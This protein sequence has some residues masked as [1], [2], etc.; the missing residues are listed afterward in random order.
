MEPHPLNLDDAKKLLLE[1]NRLANLARTGVNPIENLNNA[2]SLWRKA[3]SGFKKGTQDYAACLSNEANARSHLADL[4]NKGAKRNLQLSLLLYKQARKE[5]LRQ[6][7]EPFSINLMGEGNARLRLAR[8]GVNPEENL[9]KGIQLH[10]LSRK[11]GFLERSVNYGKS[12]MNE[13]VARMVLGELGIDPIKNL[14]DSVVLFRAS[15]NQGLSA[16]AFEYANALLNEGTSRKKL[17]EFGVDSITNLKQAI[18]LFKNARDIYS[19]NT[20]NRAETMINEGNARA[21]LSRFQKESRDELIRAIGLYTDARSIEGIKETVFYSRCLENEGTARVNLADFDVDP[22]DDLLKAIDLFEEARQGLTEGTTE[23]A[24]T[25]LNEASA[26]LKLA[27]TS[28]KREET[29]ESAELCFTKAHEFFLK[30]NN[31]IGLLKA[32]SGFGDLKFFKQD[33]SASFENLSKAI[34]IIETQRTSAKLPEYRKGYLETVIRVYKTMV[35]TCA[36]LEKFEEAFHFTESAK[37]RMFLELIGSEKK[38]F[39]A[40]PHLQKRYSDNLKLIEQIERAF[41]KGWASSSELLTL[42]SLKAIHEKILLSIKEYDPSYY[43]LQA[44]ETLPSSEVARILSGKTL[45]EYFVGDRTLIFVIGTDLKVTSVDVSESELLSK[46]IEL[47]GIINE[48]T[49]DN[50]EALNEILIFLY[51][52]LIRPVE[53][54]LSEQIVIVPHGILHLLPFQAL[55][56]NGKF[57]VDSYTA[58]FAISASLLGY[59]KAASS[60]GALVI[61]NP[62]GDLGFAELEAIQVAELLKVKP[63]IGQDATKENMLANIGEKQIIHFAGHGKFDQA[64]PMFSGIFLNDGILKALDFMNISLDTELFVLSGCSTAVS[65]ITSGDEIEG[66]LRAIHYSGSR[67]VIASLWNVCDESTFRLFKEFYG[68]SG[69]YARRLRSAENKLKDEGYSVYHWAPFQIYGN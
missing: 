54:L 6:G 67:Y 26:K 11:T 12:L 56:R 37:G 51:N 48:L 52:H 59:L 14:Q 44:V 68:K 50:A 29:L 25:Y 5:G 30:T 69:A 32:Y 58:T 17:A 4:D 2:M 9:N 20:V 21:I 45:I 1:G 36:H 15:R 7:S 55:K 60:G 13:G 64:N 42:E 22:A 53:N 57:L 65:R 10:Q 61:G 46:I 63:Y 3:R 24:T 28:K 47:R 19:P 16:I 31:I 35:L 49:V 43:S 18:N 8:L 34:K 62:T 40:P 38:P 39:K 23:F 41:L 66:L 33:Y 27:K